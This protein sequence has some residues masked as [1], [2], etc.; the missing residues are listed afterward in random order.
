MKAIQ[1]SS[2]GSSSVLQVKETERPA[3]KS[4]EVLVKVSAVTVNP[5][6]IKVR[7]GL[8]QKQMPVEFPY[9][10]GTDM[11]GTVVAVGAAVSRVKPG[12]LVFASA[13][14][15]TYAEYAV[16][17]EKLTALKP[18]GITAG[19]AAAFVVPL[20]T[21]NTL[22]FDAARIQAG[23][24]LLI[25]GAAGAVGSIMTQ[26]A[27]LLGVYVIGTASGEGLGLLKKLGADEVIDYKTQDFTR[28][29]KD[30]DVVAD[31]VGGDTQTRSFSVLKKGGRLLSIV[32]PPSQELAGKY[33]VSANFVFSAPSHIK[34]EYG[35]KL[36][37]EGKL[38]IHISKTLML[39]KAAEAQDLLEAGGINGK[40]ILQAD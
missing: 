37:E 21:A 27:K 29:V 26:M 6:D 39:E 11:C 28:L 4:D 23:E 32:S 20:N 19:E 8:M 14:N 16:S 33:G 38:S 18:K 13:S 36:I 15:G 35:T 34:L 9:T 30:V 10:P 7:K 22:L 25:H 2:F 40:I 1:Y 24:K 3:C 5:F 31:L 17:K 12:D